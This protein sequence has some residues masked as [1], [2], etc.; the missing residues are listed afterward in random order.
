MLIAILVCEIGFWVFL[1]LGLLARYPLNMPKLGMALFYATPLIDLLLLAFVMIHLRSG[2]EVHFMHGIAAL[3]IGLSVA[4]G[5]LTIASMDRLYQRKVLKR[6]VEIS[7]AKSPLA[8][9]MNYF[10]RA[11]VAMGIAAAVIA[12]VV[13]LT[14]AI[15]LEQWYGRLVSVLVIWFILGPLWVLLFPKKSAVQET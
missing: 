5:H 7:T 4:F 11:T 2:A 8:K 13:Q 12:L 6:D 1:A 14:G 10:L 15:E 3:Y 9:E